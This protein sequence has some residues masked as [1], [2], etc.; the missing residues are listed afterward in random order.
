VSRECS[1][2]YLLLLRSGKSAPWRQGRSCYWETGLLDFEVEII[3][4]P[5]NLETLKANVDRLVK[6]NSFDGEVIVAKVH[7]VSEEDEDVIY[8]LV[9]TSRESQ[10]E[11]LDQQPA[12]RIRFQ[13]IES[14]EIL[15]SHPSRT[16]PTA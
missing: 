7:F 9:S 12:Y 11:K 4:D 16:G 1:D 13:D 6:I 10:Y 14:V 15:P 8:D 3:M 5:Q 2:R